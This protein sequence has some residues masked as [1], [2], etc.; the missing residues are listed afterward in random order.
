M[1]TPSQ[2]RRQRVLIDATSL[3]GLS[4]IRGI[5]RYVRELLL[6]LSRVA[7]EFA[8]ELSL[9]ALTH[10]RPGDVRRSADLAAVAE[11]SVAEANTFDGNLF[12]CRRAMLGPVARASGAKL[13]H[14]PEMRG[15]PFPPRVPFVATCHDLI[16]LIYPET[17][18]DWH[19][20]LPLVAREV[21]LAAP[22][23]AYALG[24]VTR[25]Y[26][27][28]TRVVCISQRTADDVRDR[29]HVPSSRLDVVPSGVDIAR[30][31]RADGPRF[32][33]AAPPFA[34][35]VGYCDARK[36]IPRMFEALR[37]ANETAPLDLRWAGDIRGADLE[38][39]TALA[40]EFGVA[41]RVKFLGFVDDATL[42]ELYRDAVALLFL[43][44][45]EGFGLPVLEAM[46]AGCPTIV[47]RHSASD[48]VCGDTGIIV[49]PDDVNSAAAALVRLARDPDERAARGE[50]GAERAQLYRCETM[51]RGHLQSYQ[52]ALA[53][54]S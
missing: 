33:G 5:G 35:Y 50:R 2:P 31:R 38:K 49:D 3:R 18:L 19:V 34:L 48:E 20:A 44:R 40:H 54:S 41:E 39:M 26:R 10:L 16:P 27:L 8:P 45:L 52:R 28:A 12:A 36:N 7:P 1:T 29:L 22:A 25:R 4:G 17:Y 43:S 46:A 53:D 30:Y 14:I 21:V 6:G 15:T 51:A 13:L 24:R 47:A 42:V 37:L 11:D 32:V 9:S 23:R